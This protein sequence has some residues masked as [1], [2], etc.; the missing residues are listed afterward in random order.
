MVCQNDLRTKNQELR[1]KNRM[2]DQPLNLQSSLTERLRNRILKDGPITFRD[3]MSA[4]LYDPR[5]GYYCREGIERWGRA[6]DYRT[7]A[8]RSPLFAATFARYFVDLY[9]D[10]YRELH[11]L[12]RLTIVE[13]G[14]GA[15]HFA[16]TVL[17][18]LELQFPEVFAITN[19]V[20]CDLSA[21]SSAAV[22]NRLARFGERVDLVSF[23]RVRID[24]AGIIF[25]N[26][27]LDAFPVHRVTFS[28]GEL[29][30]LYVTLDDRGEFTWT[31]GPLSTPRISEYFQRVGVQPRHEG[32]IA[33]VSLDM[34]DWLNQAVTRLPRGYLVTVDYGDEA[35]E[36]LAAERYQG[37]LRAFRGHHFQDVLSN[38]GENDITT[39]VDWTYVKS[40]GEKLG[41]ETV[42]F[43][44]QDRFLLNAGLLEQL[45]LMAEGQGEAEKSRLRATA[46]EMILPTAMGASFQVLVQK[47]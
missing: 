38:P 47:K 17:Q 19:Y 30:E 37:T 29:L 34:G 27:L 6:G 36:L 21:A 42:L 44:R 9:V 26:E 11:Q 32:Q 25:S 10:L 43:E 4:A 2:A 39:T 18:T 1:T 15:G 8:E 23:D 14:A 20:V 12:Q 16:E 24:D 35:S 31:T 33:E 13:V 45:E 3:W 22:M 41:L 28:G 7:S 5:D 46:R 40:L